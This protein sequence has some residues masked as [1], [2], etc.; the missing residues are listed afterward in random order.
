MNENKNN[1]LYE[2]L[3]FSIITLL[4]VLPFRMYIAKPFIVNGASM[5]P[6]FETGDYLIVDEITY[7]I[8]EPERGEVVVFKYPLDPSRFFIKRIVGLPNETIEIKNGAVFIKNK[9]NPDGF[10][11]EEEYIL[12]KS[13][14]NTVYSLSDGQYFVMGDNRSNSSDSRTWG[15]L[16][17]NFIIGRAFIRLLP[18]NQIDFMPG[19]FDFIY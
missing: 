13:Y 9:N 3:K 14:K 16:D 2:V 18:L 11:L 8:N 12:N 17:K 1:F 6:T 5:S 4:I 19:N 15:S 7:K 10:Q